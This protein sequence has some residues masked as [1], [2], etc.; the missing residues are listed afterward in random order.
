MNENQ[1]WGHNSICWFGGNQHK[2]EA[3]EMNDIIQVKLRKEKKKK[4]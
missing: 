1:D 4:K 2:I 3:I